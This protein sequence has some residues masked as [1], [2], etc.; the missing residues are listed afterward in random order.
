MTQNLKPPH[1]LVLWGH[2]LADYQEMFALTE[3]DLTKRILDCYPGAASFNAEITKRH[4]HVISMDDLYRYDQTSLSIFL[5]ETFNEMLQ[6]IHQQT[7]QFDWQHVKSLDE[8]SKKRQQ[9]VKEFLSDY[10]EG[11]K[12]Q[13]YISNNMLATHFADREFDLAL[14]SHF[15]FG[16][17]E[18]QDL[19]YHVGVLN[20]LS[21]I[22]E[23]VRIFPLVDSRGN[24]SPLVGPVLLSLQQQNLG[25]EVREV[26]YQ[27]QKNGNAMMRI[28]IK[29]CAL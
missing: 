9:G 25:V 20:E 15:L 11:K 26:P 14:C 28:W 2:S 22:A 17:R 16:L 29:A 27:L 21:R 24:I 12:S 7:D 4:G 5:S 3:D 23:E 13:R 19:N 10:S 6:R 1:D 8:F 18:E